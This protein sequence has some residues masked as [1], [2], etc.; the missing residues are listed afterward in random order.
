DIAQAQLMDPR[1]RLAQHWLGEVG[2]DKARGAR[3][4]GQ[5]NA[6][7]NPDFEDAAAG[8]FRRLDGGAPGAREER[9]QNKII[10]W[11]PARIGLLD[12]AVVE[13]S[14]HCSSTVPLHR[15]I[16]MRQIHPSPG[17]F[18]DSPRLT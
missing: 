18:L 9:A 16:A 3:I 6:G 10:D 1:M 13:F 7:A 2:A 8:A 17:R 4:T 14:R 5:R 11:R 15:E 12:R